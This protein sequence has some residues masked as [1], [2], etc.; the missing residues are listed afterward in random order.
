M[1]VKLTLKVS[2]TSNSKKCIYQELL[3]SLQNQL[4][5]AKL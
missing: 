5:A 4:L 2:Q 3:T 1:V